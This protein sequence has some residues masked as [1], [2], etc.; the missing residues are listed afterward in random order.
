MTKPIK[1]AHPSGWN[2]LGS[3]NSTDEVCLRVSLRVPVQIL[4][5]A[6]T[7]L[8]LYGFE[9]AEGRIAE[10]PGI[11][12]QPGATWWARS[13]RSPEHLLVAAPTRAA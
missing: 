11:L 12:E 2:V 3:L 10:F 5:A 9:G 1:E 4:I 7:K 8:P 13:A 6:F